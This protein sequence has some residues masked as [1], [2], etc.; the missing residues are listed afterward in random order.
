[1]AHQSLI[2]G[3]LLRK[4]DQTINPACDEELYRRART[5]TCGLEQSDHVMAIGPDI[6]TTAHAAAETARFDGV[7]QG[8]EGETFP[9]R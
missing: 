8:E 1:M 3:L 6:Q 2:H 4:H 7:R 5:V 9:R